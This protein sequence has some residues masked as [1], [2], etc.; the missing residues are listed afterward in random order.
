M[1]WALET[2]KINK[3]FGS[4]TALNNVSLKVPTGSIYGYLGAN[5]SGKSTTIRILL[6]LINATSGSCT[7]FGK[8]LQH[9]LK[10]HANQIGIVPGEVRLYDDMRG[11]D[12][13][14]YFQALSEN[15]ANLRPML[16][17]QLKLSEN[18]LNKKIRAYS[19]GMKQKLLL[20]QAM[21]HNPS[22][23]ILDEPS[24]RLDPLIQNNLY[25][26][27]QEFKQNGATVFF[28]SHNL[29][30]VEKVCDHIAVIKE[31][32]LVVQ[33]KLTNLREKLPRN[34]FVEFAPHADI[35]ALEQSGMTYKKH[36]NYI[37]C[38]P[39]NGKMKQ[40][41]KKLEPYPIENISQPESAL[42]SYFMSYYKEE[43]HV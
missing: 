39:I 8:P 38:F 31:G 32:N 7:L 3:Q 2:N 36:D 34:I 40:L 25:S 6:G 26:V 43:E 9:A 29:A 1:D 11:M 41:L 42:Q 13:L 16:M 21:Q 5:G 20:I 23:L 27:L 14:N 33:D 10:I 19:Q 35:K 18:D 28:S 24:E 37:Y 22:L 30:E 12:F 15:Q 17:Q 4:F